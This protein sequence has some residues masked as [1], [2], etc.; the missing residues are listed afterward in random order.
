MII[1]GVIVQ[2]IHVYNIFFSLGEYAC[3]SFYKILTVRFHNYLRI[4]IAR[5]EMLSSK[6]FA[7]QWYQ[8]LVIKYNCYRMI[9]I[10]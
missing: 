6:N 9:S 8:G 4:D 7:R 5:V 3:C 2:S 10:R 1:H